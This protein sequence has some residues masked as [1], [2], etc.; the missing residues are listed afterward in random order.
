MEEMKINV[1][2]GPIKRRAAAEELNRI[3]GADPSCDQWLLMWSIMRWHVI[4]MFMLNESETKFLRVHFLNERRPSHKRF[5][6]EELRKIREIVWGPKYKI[7]RGSL[8]VE[9]RE[10][11]DSIRNKLTVIYEKAYRRGEIN[12]EYF[13]LSIIGQKVSPPLYIYS[14]KTRGRPVENGIDEANA[15]LI[16]LFPIVADEPRLLMLLESFYCLDNWEWSIKQHNL[17]ESFNKIYGPAEW[18]KRPDYARQRHLGAYERAKKRLK[19]AKRL[20]EKLKDFSDREERDKK[21]KDHD[22]SRG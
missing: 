15:F 11:L 8:S 18:E 22:N 6:F 4:E 17:T 3:L 1:L 19:R 21:R 14:P 2:G 9:D 10:F 16:R 7:I 13:D 5:I 20:N 12:P